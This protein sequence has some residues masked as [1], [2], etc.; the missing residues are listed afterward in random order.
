[1]AGRA[2]E[3]LEDSAPLPYRRGG[4]R[5]ASCRCAD[6]RVGADCVGPVLLYPSAS[7]GAVVAHTQQVR[8][9][10]GVAE[11]VLRR[12]RGCVIG[13]GG[14]EPVRSQPIVDRD[15]DIVGGPGQ[16]DGT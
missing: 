11:S 10:R 13:G 12:R 8:W 5:A 15:D 7:P 3:L 4:T 9:F 14:E 2:N 16:F 6:A 1:M